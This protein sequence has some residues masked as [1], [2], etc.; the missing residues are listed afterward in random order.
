MGHQL[1]FVGRNDGNVWINGIENTETCL[2]DVKGCELPDE[3]AI[4]RLLDY[5]RRFLVS[6][7][8][9]KNAE[10]S[11]I[12]KGRTHRP[13]IDRELPIVTRVDLSRLCSSKA[14]IGKERL[15]DVCDAQGGVFVCS[16]HS[17]YGITL[18]LGSGKLSRQ[19]ITGEPA[20][21]DV[22]K[23]RLPI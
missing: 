6:S 4:P 19:I 8:K 5:A 7:Q 3:E 9:S 10:L 15:Y 16:R 13:M 21:I 12:A 11:V 14:L 17:K 1:E 23:L 22:S 20:D 18:G 2:G